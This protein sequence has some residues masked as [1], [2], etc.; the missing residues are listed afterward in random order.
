[1]NYTKTSYNKLYQCKED[2]LNNIRNLSLDIRYYLNGKDFNIIK[3]NY[4][5]INF[6]NKKLFPI[7]KLQDYNNPILF[8]S[9]DKIKFQD[10]SEFEQTNFFKDMIFPDFFNKSMDHLIIEMDYDDQVIYTKLLKE[11]SMP[12]GEILDK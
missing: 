4:Q 1:M 2:H 12:L 8:Q 3:K 6:S 10:P 5:I 9:K 7:L 11:D